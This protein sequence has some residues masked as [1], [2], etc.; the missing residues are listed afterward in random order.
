MACWE[1][2]RSDG[3][4]ILWSRDN[5]SLSGTALGQ[6]AGQ[7]QSLGSIL[8]VAFTK[9]SLV[10]CRVKEGGTVTAGCLTSMSCWVGKKTGGN[11]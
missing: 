5:K 1:I 11:T 6:G 4:L 7:E 9:G 3:K 8:K 10:G 2:G